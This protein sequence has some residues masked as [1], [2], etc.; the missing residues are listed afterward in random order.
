[1][2]VRLSALHTGHFH[3]QEILLVLISVR[4]WVDPRAIVQSEGLCQWKIPMTPSGIEPATF[5]FVAQH[6]NHWDMIHP[7]SYS[8][9]A[10]TLSF[11]IFTCTHK[12]AKSNYW[13]HHACL[14]IGPTISTLHEDLY[15]FLIIS[16][17][18][19]LRMRNIS[20]KSCRESHNTH[21]CSITFFQRSLPFMRHCGIL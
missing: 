10:L 20:N 4:G 6:L 13:L 11:S 2:V 8:R 12:I 7:Y 19:L 9:K 3:P 17:S 1:M 18:V 16:C 21:L 5:W 14:P 15:T